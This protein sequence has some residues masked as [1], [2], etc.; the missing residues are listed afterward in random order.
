MDI[1]YLWNG[2]KVLL[3]WRRSLRKN[4]AIF[5][6]CK[7]E[8]DS[9]CFNIEEV[10]VD[11]SNVQREQGHLHVVHSSE[12]LWNIQLTNKVVLFRFWCRG[13]EGKTWIDS[14]ETKAEPRSLL[15]LFKSWPRGSLTNRLK[16]RLVQRERGYASYAGRIA[17][18]KIKLGAR[19]TFDSVCYI[20]N[21]HGVT[22]SV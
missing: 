22:L 18:G 21:L 14:T 9:C 12:S 7:L 20:T 6:Q 5:I 10:D 17:L 13:L 16:N 2:G 11:I 8:G 1:F 3:L 4:E 15:S 19:M